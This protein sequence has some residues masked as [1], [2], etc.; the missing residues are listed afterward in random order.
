MK[1]EI[2]QQETDKILKNCGLG[3]EICA[4]CCFH[5]ASGSPEHINYLKKETKLPKEMILQKCAECVPVK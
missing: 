3:K 1:C 4:K 5:V 2:C